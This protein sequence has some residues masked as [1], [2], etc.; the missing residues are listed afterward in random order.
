MYY[1]LIFL[2]LFLLT[3]P[4]LAAQNPLIG[5]WQTQDKD[6]VIEFYR[7]EDKFCGRFV[8]LKDDTIENPSLDNNNS[9]PAERN[10][11]LCGKTFLGDFVQGE[12]AYTNG[13]VYSPRHGSR[14]SARLNIEKVNTL[15]LHGYF[16][17]PLLGNTQIWQRIE[18]PN[19]CWALQLPK[20]LKR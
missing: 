7:C 14:F 8:W 12:G 20:R 18:K 6:G 15:A 1:K 17:L 13:W 10:T 11:P 2:T 4:A 19:L 3:T 9:D 5:Y 16:L